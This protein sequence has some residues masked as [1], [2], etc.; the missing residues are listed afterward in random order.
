M[1]GMSSDE[2]M[3]IEIDGEEARRFLVVL[4]ILYGALTASLVIY[5]VIAYVVVDQAM[6]ERPWQRPPANPT[7]FWIFVG[8]A[9]A[10]AAVIPMMRR[11]ILPRGARRA[12]GVTRVAKIPAVRA[13]GKYMSAQILSWALC[14]TIGVYGLV[15]AFTTYQPL[16][17][18]GFVVAAA[19][20][21]A[22]YAPRG[23][24]VRAVL[25]AVATGGGAGLED[26]RRP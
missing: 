6:R 23:A 26:P 22:I 24:H 4:R 8:V 12:E 25:C 1:S 9:I 21:M 5:V 10:T 17:T 3:S 18:L 16:Y 11:R 13:L 2:A 7:L 14:E 19:A 15:L 20:N